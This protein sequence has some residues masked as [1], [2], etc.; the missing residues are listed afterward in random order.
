MVTDG[1]TVQICDFGLAKWLP[2]QWTHHTISKV[3]GTFGLVKLNLPPLVILKRC[4]TCIFI[5]FSQLQLSCSW[6]LN[7]W[8]SRWK[9]RRLCLRCITTGIGHR[10]PSSWLL[11]AK[12]CIMGMSFIYKLSFNFWFFAHS[13]ASRHDNEKLKISVCL[14]L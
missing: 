4:F 8:D 9:D 1:G 12:P 6:V 7:A 5:G 2:E 14:E 10:T 11:S 3:E 13:H